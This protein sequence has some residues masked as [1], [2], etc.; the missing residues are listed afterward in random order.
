MS[1]IK[2]FI[3]NYIFKKR[4]FFLAD[5][6]TKLYN[7]MLVN[8]NFY[9]EIVNERKKLQSITNI[10]S[11]LNENK[12][13]IFLKRLE[14]LSLTLYLAL[15]KNN[16]KIAGYYWTAEAKEKP[17]WH[18][19]SYIE[20]GSVL[21]LDAYTLP[22]YRGKNTFPFLKAVAIN[23]MITSKEYNKFYSVVEESN[24]ASIRSNEK[25]GLKIVG[26]NYLLKIFKRNVFSIIHRNN[27]WEIHCVLRR[28]KGLKL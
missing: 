6:T 7:N 2:R 1:R 20:P 23:N 17:I 18:D 28:S 19:N 13:E 3:E 9:V 8:D 25:L 12:V 16:S 10:N 27:R 4:V 15:D 5:K 22:E 24:N 14:N 26:K 21:G 11:S